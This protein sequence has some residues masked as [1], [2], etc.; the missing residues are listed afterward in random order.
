M[1]TGE[2]SEE[3]SESRI[4]HQIMCGTMRNS[5]VHSLH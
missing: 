4:A 3:I 5:S 1:K 2:S